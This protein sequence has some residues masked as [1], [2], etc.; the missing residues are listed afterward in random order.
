MEA[1]I[2]KI[3]TQG[4]AITNFVKSLQQSS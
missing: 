1:A 3:Q 4:A 2:A